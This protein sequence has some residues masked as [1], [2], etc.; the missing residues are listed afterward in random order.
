MEVDMGKSKERV[1]LTSFAATAFKIHK[2]QEQDV[3]E[4]LKEYLDAGSKENIFSSKNGI[5][6]FVS[7]ADHEGGNMLELR[8]AINAHKDGILPEK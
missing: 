4:A 6:L 3:Q 8:D 7:R 1:H 5:T 2:V